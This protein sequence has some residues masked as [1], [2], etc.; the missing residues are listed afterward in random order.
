MQPVLGEFVIGDFM[1]TLR[2]YSTF[3]TLAWIAGPLLATLAARAFGL[4]W[5]R[6][7]GVYAVALVVGIAGAR[8]LDLF[9]AWDFYA[10]D[11]ARIL[12]LRFQG[13]SLYGGL[14]LAAIAAVGLA[15]LWH[16]P[17]WRLADSAV[18]GLVAGIV[19]MRTGCFLNGCC[20]GIPTDLP[21]GVTYPAGSI[22]WAEQLAHGTGGILGTALGIVRPVHPTQLYEMLAALLLGLLA[23]GL[24]KRTPPGAPF[25]AFALGF[26]L[27]RLGN[28]FLRWQ[29]SVISAP[30]WFYPAFYG[31][32]ACVLA[33]LLVWRLR[34]HDDAAGV[35]P[36]AS[37]GR[38]GRA[39]TPAGDSLPGQESRAR[40]RSS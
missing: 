3:Y 38:R 13:F 20:F 2:A 9:V 31:T 27:F 39:P 37:S 10:E 11:P 26:T 34:A 14:A 28:G 40:G 6:A 7:L 18:P 33:A 22:A 12:A 35:F 8:L 1:L 21:W 32:L 19:L 15:R 5:R 30:A 25:L 4:P 36:A 16:L 23:W 17:L 29:L 24:S